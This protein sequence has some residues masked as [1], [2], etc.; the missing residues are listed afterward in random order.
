MII[1]AFLIPYQDITVH[2][3]FSLLFHDGFRSPCTLRL[4]CCSASIAWSTIR[5][6]HVKGVFGDGGV[7]WLVILYLPIIQRLGLYRYS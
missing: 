2:E 4:G 7:S 5:E 3:P 6:Q 1:L